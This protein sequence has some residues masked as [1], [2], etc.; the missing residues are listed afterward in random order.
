MQSSAAVTNTI[1]L[2]DPLPIV[3]IK[4][5]WLTRFLPKDFI[6]THLEEKRTVGTNGTIGENF[7]FLP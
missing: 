7:T 3:L 4:V 2:V 1:E 5:Y 6:E